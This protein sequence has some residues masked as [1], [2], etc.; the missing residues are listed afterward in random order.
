MRPRHS[1]RFY[2][3]FYFLTGS[4]GF[5]GFFYSF[6]LPGQVRPALAKLSVVPVTA[7]AYHNQFKI[8]SYYNYVKQIT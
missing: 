8:I 2:P 1:C 7:L 3:G 6:S 5:S 4:T